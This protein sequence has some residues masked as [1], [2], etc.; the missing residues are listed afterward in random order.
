MEGL[1]VCVA[2][3]QSERLTDTSNLGSCWKPK[4][5]QRSACPLLERER[6]S[7]AHRLHFTCLSTALPATWDTPLSTKCA[8]CNT[9]NCQ[10][11]SDKNWGW[12]GLPIKRAEDNPILMCVSVPACDTV[13]L[14]TLALL[15]TLQGILIHVSYYGLFY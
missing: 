12:V 9:L 1:G 4:S 13:M 7:R 6:T 15:A 8:V 11:T 10:G 3:A 2:S 5:S 14:G